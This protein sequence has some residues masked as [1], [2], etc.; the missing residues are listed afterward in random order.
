[1]QT[2]KT[3]VLQ[4]PLTPD[5]IK[6][7]GVTVAHGLTMPDAIAFVK[8]HGT[9][10]ILIAS[11]THEDEAGENRAAAALS[12]AAL[13]AASPAARK[14]RLKWKT[15]CGAMGNTGDHGDIGANGEPEEEAAK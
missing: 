2:L 8:E 3:T 7:V 6:A 9:Q 12:P 13:A 11:A 10:A 14:T 5:E 15:A 1:M 4:P